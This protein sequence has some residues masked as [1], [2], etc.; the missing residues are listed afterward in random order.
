M[1][2]LD[3]YQFQIQTDDG[4]ERHFGIS[5]ERA[6]ANVIQPIFDSISAGDGAL[7]HIRWPHFAR[8]YAVGQRV[9]NAIQLRVFVELEHWPSVRKEIELRLNAGIQDKYIISFRVDPLSDWWENSENGGPEIS[10]EFTEYLHHNSMIIL[11]LL[12]KRVE[13]GL[14]HEEMQLWTWGHLFNR[15][16]CAVDPFMEDGTGIATLL[17]VHGEIDERGKKIEKPDWP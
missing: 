15:N 17:F 6:L 12:Q 8:V 2:H 11:R 14:R 4:T 13:D 10:R 1:S 3:A 5:Q 9:V 7:A 16:A